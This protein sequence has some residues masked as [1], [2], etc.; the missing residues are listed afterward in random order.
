MKKKTK[1]KN[2][3]NKRNKC[4]CEERTVSVCKMVINHALYF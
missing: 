1:N 4:E 2:K 3:E